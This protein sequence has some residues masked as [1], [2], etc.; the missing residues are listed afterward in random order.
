MEFAVRILRVE[1]VDDVPKS[2]RLSLV[3]VLGYDCVV[4]KNEDG[5][6]RHR[7]GD[8]VLYVPEAAII[9]D[10]LLK[11]HGLWGPQ[12][13]TGI[14]GGLLNG[15]GGNRVKIAV[16]RRQLSTGLVWP[17]P[18]DMADLPDLTDVAERLGIVKHHPVLDEQLLSLAMKFKPVELSFDIV[19]LKTY[20]NLL[21]GREVVI[22]EKLEG[23][24]QIAL[25]MN[26]ERH[27]DLF[28]DGRIALTT[29]GMARSGMCFRDV[30]AAHRHGI[31]RSA[32]VTNLFDKVERLADMLG[33]DRRIMLVSEAIG[34]GIKKLHY[35]HKEPSTRGIDISVDGRWL[36]ED[37]KAAAM[38]AAGIERV[39][40]LWRGIFDAEVFDGF[41]EGQTTIGGRHIREGAVATYVG[42]QDEIETELGD[43]A[44]PIVKIHSD[45]FQRKLGHDD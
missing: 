9:P 15:P 43:W 31:V 16:L 33:R 3:R 17:V 35:D 1:S 44:R 42:E 6:H 30:P 10:E 34:P 27:D 25:W 11:K 22:T 7:P 40:V 37:E 24:C 45:V 19:R 12:R 38:A 5:T 32:T 29:K 4:A 21:K 23:E 14:V 39:P 8:R 26:D 28:H 13:D 20:P 36:P 2:D 41:R 18:E